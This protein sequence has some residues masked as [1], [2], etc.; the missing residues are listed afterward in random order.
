[1]T[2]VNI[3]DGNKWHISF[4]RE[5]N[6]SLGYDFSSLYYLRAARTVNGRIIDY[7]A[8]SSIFNDHDISL[9]NAFEKIDSDY[10]ANGMFLTFG[11]QQ[12]SSS[13]D[14]SYGITAGLGSINDTDVGNEINCATTFGG[15]ISR[16]RFWSKSLS[17]KE[18]REHS[19]NIESLGVIDPTTNFNFNDKKDGTFE[20][21]RIDASVDQFVTE[22]NTSG[23]IDIFDYSQNNFH[24]SG[25]GFQYSTRVVKPEHFDYT[26]LSPHFESSISNNKVRV[27]SFISD[28]NV[29]AYDAAYAPL[30]NIPPGESPKD[31]TRFS[32]EISLTQALN[33]D[34][35]NIFATLDY[36]D[37]IIGDP[38]SQFSDD[39]KD[40]SFVSDI[41]FRRLNK[42][43][44][45]SKYFDFFKWFDTTIGDTIENLLPRKTKFLG[46]NFV[47]EQHVLERAKFSYNN[48]DMYI[49]PN[50]RY[51]LKG[52]I[53]LQQF[54]AEI[55]KF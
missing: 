16:I 30:Y 50:D 23:N 17:E 3:F 27:R 22:S 32:I 51:G 13:L 53:L 36:F 25:S 14:E 5:R 1:M 42:K 11:K 28:Q 41:Y 40:L 31:D 44:N 8:T 38:A 10:N 55:F 15:K 24:I 46:S 20:K 7:Y 39:Y 45:V 35:M 6:D 21:L 12:L 18:T 9:I 54:V 19:M 29:N 37:N 49:G 2:G 4:G 43:I 48:Y 26:I 47:V 34:I 33:E 52:Q